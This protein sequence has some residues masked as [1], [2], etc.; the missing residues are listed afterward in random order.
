[1]D[2]VTLPTN[3]IATPHS[4]CKAQ[5]AQLLR[6]LAVRI[7]LDAL[8][9]FQLNVDIEFNSIP[10]TITEN[11][12]ALRHPPTSA[13]NAKTLEPSGI[14]SR[15]NREAR[16]A[17]PSAT[18]PQRPSPRKS[19]P[20]FGYDLRRKTNPPRS[21]P[22][23]LPHQLHQRLLHRPG[24]RRTRPLPRPGQPPPHLAPLPEHE[25]APAAGTTLTADAKEVGTVTSARHCPTNPNQSAWPTPAKKAPPPGAELTFTTPE[26]SGNAIVI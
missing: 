17:A 21:R 24:N 8:P 26:L 15:K 2:D 9:E 3:P 4:P 10:C 1:M 12:S 11:P 13:S 22:R 16:A 19:I 14:F 20:W 5:T 25:R 23:G 6:D 7:D 18:R